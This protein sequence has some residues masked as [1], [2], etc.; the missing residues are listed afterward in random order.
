MPTS[1]PEQDVAGKVTMFARATQSLSS[2]NLDFAGRLGRSVRVNG[3]ARR[4]GALRRT[5]S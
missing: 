5:S 3:R 2:F 4:L 1:A